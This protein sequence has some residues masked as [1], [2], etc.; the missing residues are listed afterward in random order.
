MFLDRCPGQCPGA[1][2]GERLSGHPLVHIP[3]CRLTRVT[4]YQK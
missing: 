2:V 1:N 3:I 4:P